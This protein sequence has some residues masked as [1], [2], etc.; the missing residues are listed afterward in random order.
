MRRLASSPSISGICTS[1]STTSQGWPSTA[2]T[3]CAAAQA[4]SVSGGGLLGMWARAR[5]A[6][7]GRWDGEVSRTGVD[8]RLCRYFGLSDG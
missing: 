3:A 7:A 4:I 8:P 2:S 5:A 6:G 1:T